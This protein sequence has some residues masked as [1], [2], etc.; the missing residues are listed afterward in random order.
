MKFFKHLKSSS[1]VLLL[2]L[3][4]TNASKLDLLLATEAERGGNNGGHCICFSTSRDKLT[5]SCR[6]YRAFLVEAIDGN[7]PDDHLTFPATNTKKEVQTMLED[8]KC[9]GNLE[10]CLC[11]EGI[12]AYNDKLT[13]GTIY[14]RIGG[15]CNG[16]SI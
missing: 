6:D 4:L 3:R 8:C 16:K 9:K 5:S 12:F 13:K 2:S 14:P 7:C 10:T 1:V 11:I 15:K